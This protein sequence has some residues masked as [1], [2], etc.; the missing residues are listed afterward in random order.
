MVID[1][2][3]SIYTSTMDSVSNFMA[4]AIGLKMVIYCYTIICTST[5]DSVSNFMEMQL[6]LK[7]LIGSVE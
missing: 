5:M 1:C 4:N 3:T 6:V 2:D 7:W